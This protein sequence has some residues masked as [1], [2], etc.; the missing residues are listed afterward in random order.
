MT[1][2]ELTIARQEQLLNNF[3]HLVARRAADEAEI[4]ARHAQRDARINERF[5]NDVAQEEQSYNAERTRIEAEFEKAQVAVEKQYDDGSIN[6]ATDL[7]KQTKKIRRRFK[8]QRDTGKAERNDAREKAMAEFERAKKAPI[9]EF[10]RLKTLATQQRQMMVNLQ[11]EGEAII[12]S[13]RLKP[14]EGATYPADVST[15]SVAPMQRFADAMAR[16]RLAVTRSENLVSAKFI[17]EGYPVILFLLL[18]IITVPAAGFAFGW[19]NWTMLLGAGLGGSIV[20]NAVLCAL[21]WPLART[22]TM[23]LYNQLRRELATGE[24]ATL[25]M[26]AE[27]KAQYEPQ[28]EAL[29]AARNKTITSADGL[30]KTLL[31]K[32]ESDRDAKL[33]EVNDG[34]VERKSAIVQRRQEQL[35]ELE[36]T[37]PPQLLQW[38]RDHEARMDALRKRHTEEIAGSQ[39][40]FEEEWGVLKRDWYKGV[41]EVESFVDHMNEFCIERFPIW[42]SVDFAKYKAPKD[43]P[44]AV[45]FGEFHVPLESFP[46]GLPQSEDLA[47]ERTQFWMPALVTFPECPSLLIKAEDA[48]RDT[49]VKLMQ[50]VMLRMLAAMPPGKV[51]FTIIDPTGRGQNFSA[52]MHL[53][54]FDEQLVTSRIWTE[55]G[56][57]NKRL[58]DVT[59]HMENVIQKYL[60]NEFEAIQDYNEIAGE[61]AEPYRVLVIANYPAGFSEEA[62]KRLLS[63]AASGAR[64]GVS[65]LISVDMKEAAARKTDLADLAAHAVTLTIEPEKTSIAN[66]TLS[67]FPLTIDEPPGDATFTAGVR[68]V[69]QAAQESSRVEVPFSSVTPAPDKWWTWDSR[70]SIEVPLGRAGATKLQS[71]KLGKG[72]SQHV[73]IAGKT[74]SGKSTLLNAMITNLAAMYSPDEV[75]FY[76]VDFKKGVEFKPYATCELPQARVIAIESEREFGL[77]VLER[78]DDELKRRGDSYRQAGVQ[79]VTGWR[80]AHPGERLPRILLIVDEFQELFVAD[81][82]VAREATLL[83][84]RLVRQGRA[85]GIHVILGTQ[86]LAGAYSLARS[87]IGQMAVRIAL[88]CSESDAHLILSEDNT[89]ARLLNRPGAAIYN[90]ANG[91]MEGN[92]PFQVVW[93]ND[94]ERESYLRQ[95]KQLADERKIKTTPAIVF[96]GNVPSD[97]MKNHLLTEMLEVG[98]SAVTRSPRAWLGSAVAIKDPTFV[99]F[100]RHSGTNLL[101]VG[102]HDELSA[103]MLVTACVALAANEIASASDGDGPASEAEFIILD[104][105]RADEQGY[106]FW[107][108]AARSLTLP[109]E[110]YEPRECAKA[111]A[112]AA[113]ELQRRTLTGD[114]SA[115]PLYVVVY[116]LARFRDLQKSEDDFGFT[117]FGEEE[118]ANPGKQ[119]MQLLRE[120]PGVGIHTLIWCDSYNNLVRWVDRQSLRDLELRVLL[121]MS[122]TDSSNL[123]DSPAASTLGVNRAVFYN[124]ERG[125]YEKF[126]PYGLPTD[127]WL[128]SVRQTL[129]QRFRRAAEQTSTLPR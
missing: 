85:F 24:A 25:A 84:D 63:I 18:P 122:A 72:T 80:E 15:A 108:R 66:E 44:A 9:A 68:T 3:S 100:E 17:Y 114:D 129:G 92:N 115:P 42:E 10:A 90:D 112:K 36:A 101:M 50:N 78:L 52:F 67:H 99:R 40:I 118:K 1:D 71:M 6:I 14:A 62:S 120:G 35:A 123:I 70:G 5:Q 41:A 53:A 33:K 39:Q 28:F 11:A 106:G 91:L 34:L 7:D 38:R 127:E 79:D 107:R 110:V 32:L 119:F 16:A 105:T 126:R 26:L 65:T 124:D 46:G 57:I 45:R 103:G 73:L 93:L 102:Q 2:K 47:V 29:V 30:W 96:E 121:Q 51:R 56:H 87:T 86:T 82:R 113:A 83:L 19:T 81:D 111:I 88:Q 37:Y 116:N 104:G 95:T 125:E 64:C 128:A 60:R 48:G 4:P 76:L 109:A 58:T 77:S 97:A 75:E 61:V 23:S 49:A 89:A 27:A 43:A 55:G 74:G 21:V 98:P 22:R 117:N 31:A 13:R 8:H 94:H 54:D 69:G 12:A 20:F 59:E